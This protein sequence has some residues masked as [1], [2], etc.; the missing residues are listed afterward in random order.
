MENNTD[1]IS[2]IVPVWNAHDYLGRCIESIINQTYKRLEIILVDDGST[3][4]S[5]EICNNYRAVD[6]RIVVYHKENGGQGSAR[7][8][9]LDRCTGSFVGF[10]DNDDWIYPDM[11]KRLHE[12]MLK[13]NANIARCDDDSNTDDRG[14]ITEITETVTGKDDF[15]RFLFCDIWGGH[16]TDRLFRREL[17]GDFRFPISKTIE[18][19]R[20]IRQLLPNVSC[21]ASTNERLYYY[22]VREDN[23]SFRYA[24]TFIN[25]YERAE[26]YQSRYEE[27]IGKHPDYLDILLVKSTT[28]ACGSMRILL[29]EKKKNSEEYERMKDFLKRHKKEIMHNPGLGIKYK[30]FVA[31]L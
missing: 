9:A 29:S 13:Y 11:Y 5:L 17:I 22:T 16:V 12:I 10:V 15:H 27:A 4:D 31:I 20:F 18:D 6:S 25:S 8:Y 1:L 30:L 21:E 28:F 26:E 3:D 24:K 19:T 14:A 2:I 7:N 23:T